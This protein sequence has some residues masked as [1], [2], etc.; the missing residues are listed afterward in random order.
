MNPITE[1]FLTRQLANWEEARSR[2]AA[3]ADVQTREVAVNG[4][5][6][7][8]QFNP[9]RIVSSAARVD[10]RS[11]RERPCFLCASHCPAVQEALPFKEHYQILLNPFP[12]FP[13]H[14]TIVEQAHVPQRIAPRFGDLLE[15]AQLLTGYTV[16]YNGP[17]CGASAPDHAHFQAGNRGFLPIEQQWQHLAGAVVTACGKAVLR[18]LDDAPRN[19]LL[20]EST[21]R[22]DAERLFCRVYRALANR[23]GVTVPSDEPMMNLL[24]LYEAGHW[25][26]FL[27]PRTRHRPACYTATGEANRIISPASVDLGGVFI[28]PVEKDFKNLT[29]A[30]LTGILGEVCLSEEAVRQVCRQL[31]EEEQP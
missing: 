26:V 19:T 14:F 2:Y 13:H 30:E 20:I 22:E 6:Y 25:V 12:I 1:D 5:A 27:F 11:L 23:P 15:L 28:L 3:L 8:L 4:V 18:R 10:A 29:A 24:A 21:S 7:R 9:A 31:K 16:F 17:Q